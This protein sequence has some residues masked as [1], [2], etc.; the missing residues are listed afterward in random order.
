MYYLAKTDP[1]RAMGLGGNVELNLGTVRSYLAA[2]YPQ[3]GEAGA[4]GVFSTAGKLVLA[5]NVSRNLVA[6]DA[7][8]GQPLWHAYLGTQ[9][10]NAPESYM[11]DGHQHVLVAA[12]DTM[13]FFTL[14]Q[15]G[16]GPR[17]PRA[18]GC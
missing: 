4:G 8:S 12:G 18:L 16:G 14:N 5:G 13:S 7:V 9:V 1:R 15:R 3:L 10:S 17:R 6:Y 2:R 11:L